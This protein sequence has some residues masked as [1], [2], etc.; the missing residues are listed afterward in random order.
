MSSLRAEDHST[1][2]AILGA[3]LTPAV[4]WK[5]A[6]TVHREFPLLRISC[7]M[8]LMIYLS[9]FLGGAGIGAGV[10]LL[11][12]WTRNFTEEPLPQ[13]PPPHPHPKT[14]T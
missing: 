10:G 7:T 8:M 9:V 11:V 6:R 14:T 12:H 2:G 1:I 4:F 5:R 13:G 3:L